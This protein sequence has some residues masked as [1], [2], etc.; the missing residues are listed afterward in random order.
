[1]QYGRALCIL[2]SKAGSFGNSYQMPI[3]VQQFKLAQ[4]LKCLDY[5]LQY[6]CK[7]IR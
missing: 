7:L 2:I 1:M 4:E 5:P 3:V 6:V